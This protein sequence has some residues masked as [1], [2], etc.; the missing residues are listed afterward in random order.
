MCKRG[1]NVFKLSR[2]VAFD[3]F[4]LSTKSLLVFIVPLFTRPINT[5]RCLFTE[6][7]IFFSMSP[8]NGY[9][10]RVL[11][12]SKY[13]RKMLKRFHLLVVRVPRN[14]LGDRGS[15]MIG[16]HCYEK[17]QVIIITLK[18]CP[19]VVSRIDALRFKHFRT[20]SAILCD[21]RMEDKKKKLKTISFVRVFYICRPYTTTAPVW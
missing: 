16:I 13:F 6:I 12:A 21:I 17:Q 2:S 14:I 9:F 7:F 8:G 15:P 5:Y 10:I 11:F 19:A 18:S 4:E 1:S 20:T 3:H